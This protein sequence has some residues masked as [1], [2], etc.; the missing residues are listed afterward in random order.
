MYCSGC[1]QA[2]PLGQGICPQCGRPVPMPVPP[3]PGIEFQLA[4]YA[5]K[6]KALA[7][8]W[9]VYAGI[10][11]FFGTVGLAFANVFFSRHFGN[12]DGGPFH[13]PDWFFPAMVHFAWVILVLRS[14]LAIVAGVGL[15]Q[16]TEWGRILAIVSA[17]LSLLHP[18]FG[19]ALGIWTL[20]MLLG[21]KNSRLYEQTS[22]HI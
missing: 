18:P 9:F 3:V 5:D 15:L 21:Y 6:V 8:C 13:G 19:M 7:I 14:G 10:V 2:L 4:G 22:D 17:F 1:G 16:R 20:I 12:W 11:L